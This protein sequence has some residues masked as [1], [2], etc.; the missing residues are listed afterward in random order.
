MLLN[1]VDIVRYVKETPER[2]CATPAIPFHDGIKTNI[3]MLSRESMMV[4][5][6]E[7]PCSTDT[8]KGMGHTW[9]LELPHAHVLNFFSTL[10]AFLWQFWPYMYIIQMHFDP[11]LHLDPAR[12]GAASI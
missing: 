4:Q 7:K 1:K 8:W 3:C 2:A 10:Y 12:D 9:I 6:S 11:S 5:A